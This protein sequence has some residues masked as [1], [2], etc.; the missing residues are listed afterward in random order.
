MGVAKGYADM[1]RVQAA[2][3]SPLRR[4]ASEKMV[5]RKGFAMPLPMTQQRHISPQG[6]VLVG[7]LRTSCDLMALA[8]GSC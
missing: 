3:A 1:Y 8:K 2:T 4:R 5:E 6:K 7:V